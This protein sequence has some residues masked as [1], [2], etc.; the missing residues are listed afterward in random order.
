MAKR[1]LAKKILT[2]LF[3]HDLDFGEIRRYTD[4]SHDELTP[5]MG[6]MIELKIISFDGT[7][8]I[9]C[10]SHRPKALFTRENS[11]VEEVLAF[12]KKRRSF[13]KLKDSYDTHTGPK[14]TE[15]DWK[16]TAE[17]LHNRLLGLK[18]QIPVYLKLLGLKKVPANVEMLDKARR[19]VMLKA[20]PD[21]GG[22]TDLAQQINTAY[23]KIKAEIR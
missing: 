22:S 17:N 18:N 16:R 6:E 23:Q 14:G 20:H 3:K 19:K 21:R 12:Y 9:H 4:T 10:I 11:T 15:R 13:K 7:Y 1:N 2:L 8:K 5:V